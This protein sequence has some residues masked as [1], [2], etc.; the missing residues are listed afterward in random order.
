MKKVYIVV[1]TGR[2]I[3]GE[4]V[5]ALSDYYAIKIHKAFTNSEKANEFCAGLKKEW[6]EMVQTPEGPI[7]CYCT[8]VG[9]QVVE[10]EE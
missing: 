7:K 9:V 5:A 3:T 4:S 10:V 8:N 6:E 2:Q 1:S